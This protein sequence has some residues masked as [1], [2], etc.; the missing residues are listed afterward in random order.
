MTPATARANVKVV[1]LYTVVLA[2]LSAKRV[3]LWRSHHILK[4]SDPPTPAYSRD[5]RA[6][7]VAC[8]QL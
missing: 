2:M 3:S 8:V 7:G 4:F 1:V 6:P 5:E